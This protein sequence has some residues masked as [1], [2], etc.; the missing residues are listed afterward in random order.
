MAFNSAARSRSRGASRQVGSGAPG[1]LEPVSSSPRSAVVPLLSPSSLATSTAPH[2]QH[3]ARDGSPRS[4]QH[5]PS[6]H[7]TLDTVLVVLACGACVVMVVF[8]AYMHRLRHLAPIALPPPLSAAVKEHL[9][10]G[11][12]TLLESTDA[13]QVFGVVQ[14][15]GVPRPRIVFTVST[16]PGEEA[17]LQQTVQSLMAQRR[18]FDHG[19]IVVP[20]AQHTASSSSAMD[21]NLHLHAG[22]MRKI[23]VLRPTRDL[24]TVSHLVHAVAAEAHGPSTIV[25]TVDADKVYSPHFVEA[26]EARMVL[27]PSVA[28]S[29]CGWVHDTLPALLGG[30]HMTLRPPAFTRSLHGLE[31]DVLVGHCGAAYR[32]GFLNAS[33]LAQGVLPMC[34]EMH[35]V[36]VSYYLAQRGIKRVAMQGEMGHIQLAAPA[37][38]AWKIQQRQRDGEAGEEVEEMGSLSCMYWLEREYGK[39][40]VS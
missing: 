36:W 19:Y 15:A 10:P 35:S 34:W 39:W 3:G 20:G 22:W 29:A 11:E 1:L 30:G 21:L 28:V 16:R 40:P 9:Q 7:S 32:V 17:T 23:T 26:L 13:L 18:R 5:P 12:E 6:P 37:T 4:K 14:R 8:F 2:A 24:G 27:D 25:V 38:A 31:V 33:E